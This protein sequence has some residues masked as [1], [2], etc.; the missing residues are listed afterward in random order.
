MTQED[1]NCCYSGTNTGLRLTGKDK[2]P[3]GF[4]PPTC[5][6]FAGLRKE[7]E[8]AERKE[9]SLLFHGVTR[10]S[11]CASAVN[12]VPPRTFSSQTWLGA[13]YGL[14]SV[15]QSIAVAFSRTLIPA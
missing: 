7:R 10:R 14:T 1:R 13:P 3:A 9:N 5:R 11:L 4:S 15:R 2:L 8:V 12:G 6:D